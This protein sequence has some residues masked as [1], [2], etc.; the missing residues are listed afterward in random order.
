MTISSGPLPLLPV[1]AMGSS[2]VIGV[3][4]G[5]GGQGQAG[6]DVYLLYISVFTTVLY[7]FIGCPDWKVPNE[8]WRSGWIAIPP[9]PLPLLPEQAVAI[10]TLDYFQGSFMGIGVNTV[11]FTFLL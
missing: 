4:Q 7:Y 11:L 8:T 6:R 2:V 1:W 3:G 9:S 5:R 10:R